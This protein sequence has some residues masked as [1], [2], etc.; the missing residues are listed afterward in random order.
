MSRMLRYRLV[1]I[2]LV[3]T[4][5]ATQSLAFADTRSE[6]VDA[7]KALDGADFEN[8]SVKKRDALFGAVSA[9][10]HPDTVRIVANVVAQFATYIDVLEYRSAQLTEKLAP[11]IKKA[12]MTDQQIGLRASYLRKLKKNEQYTRYAMRSLDLMVES[13][14]QWKGAKTLQSALG[15][16]PTAPTA[17][18]RAVS[19]LACGAWHK[20]I[21]SASLSKRLFKTL[22]QLSRDKEYIVRTAV[23]RSTAKFNRAEVV[24]VLKACLNDPD[25]RVR[26]AAIRSI[27]TSPSDAGVGL[28]I[29]RMKKEKGRLK[30]DIMAALKRVTGQNHRWEEQW[31][32]WWKGVGEHIPPKGATPVQVEAIE[33][34]KQKRNSFYGIETRSQRIAFVIDM[35]GSMKHK[36]EQ[37]KKGPITGKKKSESSVGGKTRWDVARN[38]LKRAI[39]NL[40]SKA[41]FAIILFNHSVQ[42]WQEEM[43]QATP[44][45]KKS[46]IEMIDK[47]NPRGATY[48][49]GALREAFGLAGVGEKV[50]KK[51]KKDGPKIDTI[52]MLSDGGPTDA[53]MDKPQPMEADPILE[54]VRGWNKD[55]GVVIHCIAVH[56]DVIGT[57]FLKKL[58]AQNNGQFVVRE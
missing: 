5:L 10:D 37:L 21:Q 30:D 33:K 40:N 50:S 35:S 52:F 9:Y 46:A 8:M 29:A 16:L 11:Y 1:V 13:M 31:S 57:E 26:A 27:E 6:F 20:N 49:L 56:T 3:A 44:D 42:P 58:A 22:K 15:T 38:E 55:L 2:A 25:W 45:N 28:L 4:L 51:K 18:V 23:A 47:I 14:G 32:G 43:I 54:Q 41:Y 7:R 39:R 17:R 36:T 53:K 48:S 24:P 34:K 12:A 19:A